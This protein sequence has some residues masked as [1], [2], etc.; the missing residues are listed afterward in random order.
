MRVVH[1]E[2]RQHVSCFGGLAPVLVVALHA[3]TVGKRADV[4]TVHG[5]CIGLAGY[6]LAEEN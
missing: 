2:P 5:L 3:G 1:P 6:R 4:N